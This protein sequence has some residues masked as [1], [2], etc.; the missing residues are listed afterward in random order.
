MSFQNISRP[1]LLTIIAGS[2][3]SFF[4]GVYAAELNTTSSIEA[5]TVF[6]GSAKVT[7]IATLKIPSGESTLEISDLPMRLIQS[8]LRVSGA[9]DADVTLGS[10][11]LK[12]KINTELVLEKERNLKNQIDTLN[13]QRSSLQDQIKRQQSKLEYISAMGS[14]GSSDAGSRYLQLPMEQMARGMENTGGCNSECSAADS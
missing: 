11:S 8:S 3:F 6:P 1:I 7:R 5:I 4:T 2:T 10:V 9:S 12:N 14:G 13:Q